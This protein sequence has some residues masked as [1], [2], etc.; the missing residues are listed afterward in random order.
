MLYIFDQLVCVRVCMFRRGDDFSAKIPI[1]F[2][3]Y[4]LLVFCGLCKDFSDG[5][6]FS[7][8]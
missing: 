5:S 8:V 3:G 4:F 6:R 1:F 7:I 2:V